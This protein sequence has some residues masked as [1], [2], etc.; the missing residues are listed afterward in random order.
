MVLVR[1]NLCVPK[2]ETNEQITE[3]LMLTVNINVNWGLCIG[4]NPGIIL[5]Y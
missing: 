4:K 1:T 5:T 2:G 3:I